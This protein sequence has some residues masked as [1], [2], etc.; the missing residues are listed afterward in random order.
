MAGEHLKRGYLILINA[1][2][3]FKMTLDSPIERM[4]SLFGIA[5]ECESV[6]WSVNFIKCKYRYH[7]FQMQT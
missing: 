2:F 6:V 4:L 1:N 7:G 5:W 3:D